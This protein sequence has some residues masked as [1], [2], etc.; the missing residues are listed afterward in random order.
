MDFKNEITDDH[1]GTMS[2]FDLKRK[3]SIESIIKYNHKKI[4][5][6]NLSLQRGVFKLNIHF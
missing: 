1:M 2:K 3:K 5:N 4:K 6:K